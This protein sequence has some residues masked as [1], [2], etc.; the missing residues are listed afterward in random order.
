MDYLLFAI[1]LGGVLL[2]ANILV[3]GASRLA[4]RLGVPPIVV[5]LTIV[6]F[7]T[8]APEI[9]VS[10]IASATGDP[11]TALGNVVGSNVANIGLVLGV[12]ALMSPMIPDRTVL[13][14][15]GPVMVLVSV[16]FLLL[17]FSGEYTRWQGAIM[18]LVLAVFLYLSF[19]W[20][21]EDAPPAML[22]DVED[23]PVA[24]GRAA[25]IPLQIGYV[26]V[27][28]AMLFGG[29]QALIDGRD[30]HRGDVRHPQFVIAS[31]LIAIGTSVPEL[32]TSV[33]ASMKKE[34]DIAVG[35]VI[36]S[37]LFNLLAVLGIASVIADIPIDTTVQRLDMPIMVGFSVVALIFAR[38]GH[39]MDRW[40]G[41]VLLVA[42]VSYMALLLLR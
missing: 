26:V 10:G 40:E 21:R 14:R 42:Y 34:A 31:T 2:G 8:S 22:G 17:A 12:T 1:G 15:E 24:T 38:S 36:G 19:R 39:K 20:S 35:N 27:G 33:V 37:N 11:D 30:R 4:A 29:G 6:G 28:I 32:A 13:R 41:A 16:A 23:I 3:Q 18:L 25:N 9:I 5:G 7:G